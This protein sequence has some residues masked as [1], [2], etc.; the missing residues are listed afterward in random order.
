MFNPLVE[1]FSQ[2]KDEDIEK[3]Y[4]DLN[5]KIGIAQR[6]GNGLIV[7]QMVVVLYQLKEEMLK[8]QN[9]ATKRLM[10]IHDKDYN[11]LIK[12]G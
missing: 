3:R 2:L 6:M 10:K 9:E 4:S 12:T 11:D 8:R 1:D 5:K 7:N